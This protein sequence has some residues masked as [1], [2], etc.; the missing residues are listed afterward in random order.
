MRSLCK[1][2]GIDGTTV[3]GFDDT[4]WKTVE[5]FRAYDDP[6]HHRKITPLITIKPPMY[7]VRSI[8][9]DPMHL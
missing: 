6:E 3:Y 8:V 9:L 1:F 7:M 5:S 4:C 2:S